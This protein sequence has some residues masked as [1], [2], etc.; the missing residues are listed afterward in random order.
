[1]HHEQ[2]IARLANRLGLRKLEFNDDAVCRLILD[3]RH[4]IDI[5]WVEHGESIYLYAV[6]HSCASALS[7]RYAELLAAN[8]FGRS[9][10]DAVLG[11]DEH[12]DEVLLTRK[13]NLVNLDMEW[14]VVQLEGFVDAVAKWADRLEHPFVRAESDHGSAVA[15][16]SAAGLLRV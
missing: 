8:L 9:T 1:M 5:E 7:S 12:R 14:F 15:D 13:F 10:H 6:V 4:A 16:E 11:L 2:F 3:Q